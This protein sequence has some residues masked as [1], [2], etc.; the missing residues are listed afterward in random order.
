MNS[1][2]ERIEFEKQMIRTDL[3]RGLIGME[4]N[5]VMRNT[6]T[7][8]RGGVTLHGYFRNVDDKSETIGRRYYIEPSDMDELMKLKTSEEVYEYYQNMGYF[9]E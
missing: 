4:G 1:L 7:D 6:S 8:I 2:Q 5:L 9:K 3:I